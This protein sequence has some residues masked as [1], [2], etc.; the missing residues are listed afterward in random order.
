[1]K[2]Q[3][4]DDLS[5]GIGIIDDQHKK[6]VE[7]VASF[8]EAVN[9]KDM[10]TVE[11]TVRYLIGY[12]IQHFGSE[13]LIMIRHG[14]KDFKQHRDEHSCFIKMVYDINVDL[15]AEQ[16]TLEQIEL[17]SN[18]LVQWIM[19]HIKISDKQLA[20]EIHF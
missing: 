15:L 4:S 17:F 3:W 7:R 2:V 12:A 6:L 16:L 10:Q 5:I 20:Q 19:N 9:A 8:I 18:K 14:Y 13:E 1:M 11:E